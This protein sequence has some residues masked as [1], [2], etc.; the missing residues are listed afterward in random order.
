MPKKMIPT[1]ITPTA[2][3]RLLMW[4]RVGE[5][6]VVEYALGLLRVPAGTQVRPEPFRF[7]NHH[8]G[9]GNNPLIVTFHIG[10][11]VVKVVEVTLPPEDFAL[12]VARSAVPT[13]NLARV[14]LDDEDAFWLWNCSGEDAGTMRVYVRPAARLPPRAT[15]RP[16]DA[17][18]FVLPPDAA[19]FVLEGSYVFL[20]PEVVEAY[21]RA[22][23]VFLGVP[24][25]TI[26]LDLSCPSSGICFEAGAVGGQMFPM[27]E[28]V[29]HDLLAFAGLYPTEPPLRLDFDRINENL[30][31]AIQPDGVR[32]FMT[33][34]EE[35]GTA[36]S[37]GPNQP[38]TPEPK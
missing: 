13:L 26:Q 17:A 31:E 5:L 34:E 28:D 22:W 23:L 30:S 19:C 14:C 1:E 29:A 35:T 9:R 25:D 11:K 36:E 16:P 6:Q 21:V 38:L 3:P 32:L 8:S 10:S 2:V 24:A 27:E 7:S 4:V 15:C 12:R 37:I 18:C 33:D 20:N